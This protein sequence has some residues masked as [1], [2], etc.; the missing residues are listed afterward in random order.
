MQP[1]VFVRD[2]STEERQA[3]TDGLRS[4]AA[5]VLRRSQILFAGVRGER[6]PCIAQELGCSDQAVLNAIAAC[7]T[8]GCAVLTPG[9]PV[10]HTLHRAFDDAADARLTAL[11][12]RS[13]RDFDLP[14]SLCTLALLTEVGFQEGLT[15]ERVSAE[16]VRATLVRRW[17]R[18]HNRAVKQDGTG[19][20]FVAC[21]LPSS[22][23]WLNP[24]EPHW[25]HGKRLVAEP[26]RLLTAEELE[27]RV[28][29]TFQA[30]RHDHLTD[31][32]DLA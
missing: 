7:G 2:L 27:A 11:L 22:C 26:A 4:P 29:A 13:P 3:L 17:L 32:K 20:R 5:F 30:P 16:R 6:A 1:P 19:V 18:A 28:W 31:T 24:I 14:I 25:M 10:A 8:T 21:F 12:L 9:S 15:S 23:P